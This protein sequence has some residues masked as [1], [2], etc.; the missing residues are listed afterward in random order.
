MNAWLIQ[1]THAL[2]FRL[3]FY[4]GGP[5]GHSVRHQHWLG[6]AI[7]SM[8]WPPAWCWGAYSALSWWK[9]EAWQICIGA[10]DLV[11]LVLQERSFFHPWP[12][13]LLGGPVQTLHATWGGTWTILKDQRS[14]SCIQYI[15]NYVCIYVGSPF[16]FT[17]CID[18]RVAYCISWFQLIY[19]QVYHSF[20]LILT[21]DPS[22]SKTIH[23]SS[24][25][26][27]LGSHT[28]ANVAV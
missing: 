13:A 14:I 9:I 2:D 18:A 23:I 7:P 5:H 17:K 11:V 27:L 24:R 26:L 16:R 6:G 25:F 22:E 28:T 3:S 20:T 21:D 19:T 15:Y 1:W 10:E 8:R 12:R 4:P